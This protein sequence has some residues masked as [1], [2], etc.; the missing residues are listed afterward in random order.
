[1]DDFSFKVV[2]LTF[3]DKNMP[4]AMGYNVFSG[5]IVRYGRIC[6]KLDKFLLRTNKIFSLYCSRGYD[7]NRLLMLISKVLFNHAYIL[8]KYGLTSSIQVKTHLK[9]SVTEAAS[10]S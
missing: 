8:H 6:S 10:P 7:F 9:Y 5:Q 3:P 4:I 2:S 1:M